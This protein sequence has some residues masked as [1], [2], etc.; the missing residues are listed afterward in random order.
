MGAPRRLHD[1]FAELRLWWGGVPE[2]ADLR[3]TRSDRSD[4]EQESL[5][6]F[7]TSPLPR[8]GGVN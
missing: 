4:S 2:E 7:L 5:A 3:D 1:K 8:L 6:P